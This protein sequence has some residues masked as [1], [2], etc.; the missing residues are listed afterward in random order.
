[1]SKSITQDLKFRESVVK[2][3]IKHNNNSYAA[4]KYKT[5]REFVRYWRSRYDGTIDSLRYRSRAPLNPRNRQS[6]ESINIVRHTLKYNVKKQLIECFVI[7]K[8]KG[9]SYS[10]STFVATVRRLK[11]GFVKTLE[12]RKNKPYDTPKVPG[13]KVQC[14]TKFVPR[15]CYNNDE[16]RWCQFTFIDETTRIRYLHPARECN[17][18]ESTKALAAAITFYSKLDINIQLIQTDNGS[19]FTNRF[20]SDNRLSLFESSLD[21]Y[22]IKHYKIKPRTPRHNGKVERSHRTD[23]QRFYSRHTFQS[24]EDFSRKLVKHNYTYNRFPLL[25]FNMQSPLQLLCKYKLSI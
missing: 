9:F 2:C 14:D 10:Y 15:S 4:Q 23:N 17:S 7:A 22:G 1:M 12:K 6:E 3:A 20:Q 8:R 21:A 24:F 16:E 18:F 19:E 13:L 25:S 11:K 5:T